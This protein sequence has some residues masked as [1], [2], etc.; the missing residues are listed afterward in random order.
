[1][2]RIFLPVGQGAFYCE[3]FTKAEYGRDVAVIY[4]CG[5][6]SD[7]NHIQD[8][9]DKNFYG[10]KIIEALFISHFDRDHVNGVPLLF[11][12]F[13]IRRIYFPMLTKGDKILLS[14]ANKLKRH[15]DDDFVNEFIDDP[16]GCLR[17]F[18]KNKEEM[19]ELIAV[20]QEEEDVFKYGGEDLDPELRESAYDNVK[21][22]NPSENRDGLNWFYNGGG[23][24][25]YC[26]RY[27]PHN[28][29][30]VDRINILVKAL[31]KRGIGVNDL[32]IGF[33]SPEK[34]TL[35]KDAYKEVP[36]SFNTNSMTLYSGPCGK[37]GWSRVVSVRRTQ[38]FC[39][40]KCA[41]HKAGCLY[42]GDYDASGSNKWKSLTNAYN[43]WWNGI[44]CVQIPHHGS[45]HSYNSG[46]CEMDAV[47]I[48]SAGIGNQFH[49]PHKEVVI[50]LLG[51]GRQLYV[52]TEFSAS[53]VDFMV[54]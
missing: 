27:V 38:R 9:I 4:D 51:K 6:L 8:C 45:W 50:D 32:E 33:S 7:K 54:R 34:L 19:P 31:R 53:K 24:C 40:L 44:G 39:R 22:Y 49:H 28:F 1:M 30:Q 16:F 5:T 15:A 43:K 14:V 36:G 52:V 35:I 37:N 2:R 42:T 17:K 18:V 46:F 41:S 48:V 26:W 29:R 12:K 21:T 47:F 25:T 13:K 3:K 10:I 11:E 20:L 23:G